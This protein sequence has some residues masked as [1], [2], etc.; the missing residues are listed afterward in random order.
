MVW[1]DTVILKFDGASRHNPRGPAGC[2]WVLYDEDESH[3]IETGKD[4]LGF[5]VSNNQAEYQGL[6][7]GLRYIQDN[8]SCNRV[9]VRGD[10][11]IV[12]RQMLGEYNV[13]SHNIRSYFD[14]AKEI[15]NDLDRNG[16]KIYYDHISRADNWK[17]DKLANSAIDD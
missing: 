6:I 3:E 12:I 4:D 15:E 2:G 9:Y 14:K 17:A 11:E 16:V 10:S 8:I 13:N 5:N 7:D 1:Y